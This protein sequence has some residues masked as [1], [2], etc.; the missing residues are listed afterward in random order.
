MPIRTKRILDVLLLV[1]LGSHSLIAE[2]WRVDYE[3]YLVDTKGMSLL[4]KNYGDGF[5]T[6]SDK[7][8]EV[9]RNAE[10]SRIVASF[11]GSALMPT[12]Q[13]ITQKSGDKNWESSLLLKTSRIVVDRAISLD[14]LVFSVQ[15]SDELLP[16]KHN[17]KYNDLKI[18][19]GEQLVP[20]SIVGSENEGG[21]IE[22]VSI[23]AL[24]FTLTP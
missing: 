16:K 19:S 8:L 13:I 24:R 17:M 22:Y 1:L 5:T 2:E 9:A 4:K 14:E 12:D 20:V 6:L 18:F 15:G 7:L 11:S 23:F 21:T 3:Y 10:R